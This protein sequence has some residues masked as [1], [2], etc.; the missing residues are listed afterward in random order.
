MV[1]PYA[2]SV[3]D[4]PGMAITRSRRTCGISGGGTTIEPA[5]APV[6]PS[7]SAAVRSMTSCAPTSPTTASVSTAGRTYRPWKRTI[8]SRSMR[9]RLAM[10]PF[11]RRPAH[12][13]RDLRQRLDQARPAAHRLD[14]QAAPELELAADVERLAAPGRGEAHA[15]LAH[16]LH[17]G[18]ALLDQ[19]LGQVGIAAVLGDARHVVEELL[20]GVGAE[21]GARDLLVAEVR[22]Q[23]LAGPRRRYRRC[24]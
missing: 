9:S 19:E 11:A 13:L 16:P 20:F 8:A 7:S 1:N 14:R 12:I 18:K 24:A 22:D 21:V 3:C 15:L 17:R 6:Q 10:V 5:G 23:R 2:I 4:F